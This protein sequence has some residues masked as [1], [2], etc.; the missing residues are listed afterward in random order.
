MDAVGP[1]QQAACHLIGSR[2]C[3]KA[4][5]HLPLIVDP[6]AGGAHAKPDRVIAGKLAKPVIQRHM[7]PAAV[8]R[9]LRPVVACIG[10]TRLGI[11]F[12]TMG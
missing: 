7:E 6:V 2:I 3:I 8:R 10:A 5:R 1:D 12:L 11:D 4:H 9:I